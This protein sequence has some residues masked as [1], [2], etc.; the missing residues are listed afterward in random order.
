MK[1]ENLIDEKWKQYVQ[2]KLKDYTA[3]PSP[4]VWEKISTQI[5]PYKRPKNGL[6]TWITIGTILLL[7]IGLFYWIERMPAPV[8]TAAQRSVKLNNKPIQEAQTTIE[9]KNP[10]TKNKGIIQ[11]IPPA[12]EQSKPFNRPK[13]NIVSTPSKKDSLRTTPV[14]SPQ[15]D[16]IKVPK[17]HIALLAIQAQVLPS[18]TPTTLFIS[19]PEIADNAPVAQPKPALFNLQSIENGLHL[20]I[21]KLFP[22]KKTADLLEKTED[23]LDNGITLNF[24]KPK[25]IFKKQNHETNS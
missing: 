18:N 14:L 2:D 21:Q 23:F 11:S 20:P 10:Q 12:S 16:T 17:V 19:T 13:Q 3:E 7:S 15:I 1:K 22:V 25:S 24:N 6:G 5:V 8:Y 4:A 9:F